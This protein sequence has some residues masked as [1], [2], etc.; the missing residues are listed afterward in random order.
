VTHHRC[1]LRHNRHAVCCSDSG[2]C[3]RGFPKPYQDRTF[4]VE[5]KF[6]LYQRSRNNEKNQWIVPYN[7]YILKKYEAHWN[8]ELRASILGVKYLY[9]C[10]FKGYDTANLVI[11][12]SDEKTLN[13]NE[14]EQHVQAHYFSSCEAF[15]IIKSFSQENAQSLHNDSISM[16]RTDRPLSS[17]ST[18]WTNP[19]NLLRKSPA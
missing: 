13:Y 11:S 16:K 19:K 17:T 3:T 2:E 1:G 6:P 12:S 8:V 4:F 15:F 14:I 9:K 18:I 10:I 5:N 7:P